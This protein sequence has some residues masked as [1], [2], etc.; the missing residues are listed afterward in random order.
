MTDQKTAQPAR[1]MAR[2]LGALSAT[3]A[4][5]GTSQAIAVTTFTPRP[6]S[7]IA[8]VIRLLE[9]T[10]GASIE[11]IVAATSWLH[12]STRAALTGLKT[13]GWVITKIRCDNVTRYFIAGL[14][15]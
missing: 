13:K 9:R 4:S 11:E 3:T 5:N 7:K 12:H 1:R 10:E 2:P 6:E 14:G 8:L 15:A